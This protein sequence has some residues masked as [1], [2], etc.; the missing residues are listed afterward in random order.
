MML[1]LLARNTASAIAIIIISMGSHWLHC[2]CEDGEG[3]KRKR[4]WLV[5]E[6]IGRNNLP[7]S[8]SSPMENLG[9]VEEKKLFTSLSL[10]LSPPVG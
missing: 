2:L 9:L 3:E 5:G 10:T 4:P 8:H 7:S 6:D 1:S